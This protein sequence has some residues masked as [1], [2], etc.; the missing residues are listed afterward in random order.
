MDIIF[1]NLLKTEDKESNLQKAVYE[2]RGGMQR[3]PFL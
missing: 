1:I 3:P 2:Y